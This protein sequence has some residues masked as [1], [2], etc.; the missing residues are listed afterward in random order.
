MSPVSGPE[1]KDP[2]RPSEGVVEEDED[3]EGQPV[4]AGVDVNEATL[5][6]PDT[7]HGEE[8][9]EDSRKKHEEMAEE[10]EAERS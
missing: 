1:D 6:E 7:L 2:A 4:A 9:L 8:G 5:S 10:D 3:A